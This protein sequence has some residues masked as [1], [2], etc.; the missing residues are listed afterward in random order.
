M[1]LFIIYKL[2][3]SKFISIVETII[4][5]SL[6]NKFLCPTAYSISS[7]RSNKH[8]KLS[9]FEPK[10]LIST[11]PKICS[12]CRLP[13]RLFHYSRCS[14][15]NPILSYIPLLISHLPFK[16]PAISTNYK[17]KYSTNQSIPKHLITV[18]LD[19]IICVYL[20]AKG[21]PMT[22]LPPTL[23]RPIYFFHLLIP[24]HTV[25]SHHFS[26][27]NKYSNGFPSH[28]E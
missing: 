5:K 8:L 11:S 7:L 26:M 3:I 1:V 16:P 19:S 10:F 21:S 4:I 25:G 13:T 24:K 15:Q 6:L 23:P 9:M 12:F 18:T 27:P 20:T 28:L 2:S 14:G 22:S 17:L